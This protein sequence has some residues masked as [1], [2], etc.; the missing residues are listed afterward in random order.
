MKLYWTYKQAIPELAL[1]APDVRKRL[2]RRYGFAGWDML[3]MMLISVIIA[4]LP[5]LI[6]L[7]FVH[8]NW[9]EQVPLWA[10]QVLPMLTGAASVLGW[11]QIHFRLVRRSIR[12]HLPEL[13]ARCGYC[14]VGL[15]EPRC[16]E[17]GTPFDPSIPRSQTR[18]ESLMQKNAKL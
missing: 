14:L 4:W 12:R 5:I 13:C 17:C 9:T 10:F 3:A 6:Y 2:L 11:S 18:V 1:F 8:L 7:I 15:P 16:P